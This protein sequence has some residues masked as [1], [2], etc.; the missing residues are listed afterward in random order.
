[1]LLAA[2][3]PVEAGGGMRPDFRMQEQL[4]R[5]VLIPAICPQAAAVES[6]HGA[7]P[8]L[9]AKIGVGAGLGCRLREERRGWGK[10]AGEQAVTKKGRK[11][12]AV[13]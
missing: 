8:E 13:S 4:I 12:A 2:G 6:P 9:Q 5:R 10:Q 1:V 3:Y 7:R 11:Q